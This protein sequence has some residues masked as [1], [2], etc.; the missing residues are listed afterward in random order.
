MATISI[1]GPGNREF[2]YQKLQ[3]ISKQDLEEEIKQISKVLKETNS[4]LE[5]LPDKGIAFDIGIEYKL[6]GGKKIIATAPLSDK[7]VGIAHLKKYIDFKI[8]NKKLI[9][10][11][12][13][14][15]DWAKTNQVKGLFGDAILYL[16]NTFGT[17]M[18]L[19]SSAYMYK[20]HHGNKNFPLSKINKNL[21]A[22]KRNA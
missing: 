8:D 18:E 7:K 16:G 14:G 17:Q 22:G 13:D 11:L 5:F 9:N 10:K 6:Q 21:I 20:W 19:N 12:Q 4:T 2:Y 3:K 1:L 15:G